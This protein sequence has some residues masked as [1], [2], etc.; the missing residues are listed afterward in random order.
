MSRSVCRSVGA[1]V[2]VYLLLLLQRSVLHELCRRVSASLLALW[3]ELYAL[4]PPAVL[5]GARECE[6]AG[7]VA[8]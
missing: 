6:V 2:P 5:I 7:V 3:L 1:S 4:Q 8:V